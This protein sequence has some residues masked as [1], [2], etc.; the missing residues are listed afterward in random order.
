MKTLQINLPDE[1]AARF[2]QLAAAQ[3]D[4]YASVNT[5]EVTGRDA[6][7]TDLLVLGL[8]ELTAGEEAFPDQG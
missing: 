2:E 8:E 1:V 4:D 6:L 3:G 5:S 7:F